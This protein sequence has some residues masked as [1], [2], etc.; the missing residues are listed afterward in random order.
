MT[1]VPAVISTSWRISTEQAY[2][3]S[4]KALPEVYGILFAGKSARAES[5]RKKGLPILR[6]LHP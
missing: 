5:M 4:T 6:N 3:Y 2:I 1:S